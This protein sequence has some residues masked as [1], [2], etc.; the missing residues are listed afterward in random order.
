MESISKSLSEIIQDLRKFRD[1]REWAQ[2]HTP[3]HLAA[4][5]SI[6]AAELME[7]MLWKSDAE[8]ESMISSED[9]RKRAQ[10]E[11]ADVLILSLL[12]CD[13]LGLDPIASI[14]QKVKDNEGKYPVHLAKGTATKYSDL[15]K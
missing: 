1:E 15:K 7:T 6:E 13:R 12:F 5:I 14:A 4:A 8:V 2:F 3:K 9:G 11:I 10:E